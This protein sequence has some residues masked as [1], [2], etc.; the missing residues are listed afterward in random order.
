MKG[1]VFGVTVVVAILATCLIPNHIPADPSEAL[2][3]LLR[4]RPAAD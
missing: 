2:L 1:T 4:L 3:L